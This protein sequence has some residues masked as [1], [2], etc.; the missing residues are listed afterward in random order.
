MDK[1]NN[2]K[3]IDNSKTNTKEDERRKVITTKN[4]K[5]IMSIMERYAREI[6]NYKPTK[7]K[8]GFKY[9]GIPIER[10]EEIMGV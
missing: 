6:K 8:N 2:T 1:E 5:M 10:A 3:M 4:R 9:I 7:L